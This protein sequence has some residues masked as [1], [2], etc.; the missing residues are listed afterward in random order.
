MVGF[1]GVALIS[2]GAGGEMG[3]DPGALLV[4]LAAASASVYFA[5]QKPYLEKYGSLTFTSYAVWAGALWL[6]PFLPQTVEEAPRASLG[7]TLSV[8]YLGVFPTAVA[9]A[10]AAYVFSRLPVSRAVTLEYLFPPVAI[11]IAWV[12][13]G[14]VPSVL[15]MLGGAV[16]LAGVALVNRRGGS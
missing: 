15:S 3:F 4:L 2:S 5:F 8:V 9:Y 7:A 1:L 12:W 16:A 11:A 13:L 14:E 10:T 6:L